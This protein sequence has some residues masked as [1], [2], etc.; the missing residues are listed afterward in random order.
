MPPPRCHDPDDRRGALRVGSLDD[1]SK[2]S[3]SD[4]RRPSFDDRRPPPPPAA[5][6]DRRLPLDDRPMRRLPAS[7]IRALPEDRTRPV[8]DAIPLA[9]ATTGDDQG[10]HPTE[11]A[12]D[13]RP[14]GIVPLEERLLQLAPT[15]SLQDRLSQPAVPARGDI[16]AAPSLE[17][18]LSSGPDLSLA[19]MLYD[20]LNKLPSPFVAAS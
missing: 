12:A 8:A 2:A 9:R 16:A 4:D 20:Q 5:G 7:D 13:E 15:P 1:R 18:R 6:D 19:V 14:R 17:E 10:S 3:P 11:L